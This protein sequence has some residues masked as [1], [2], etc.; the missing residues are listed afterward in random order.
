[1][2]SSNIFPATLVFDAQRHVV[3]VNDQPIVLS[4]TEFRILE[5]LA[6]SPGRAFSREQILDGLYGDKY[7]ITPRAVD[8][9]MVG[10]R[11]KLG[12]AAA[13]I[14]TVRGLGYRLQDGR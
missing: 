6:A 7:A 5:F 2:N 1:M 11:R 13:A 14:E 8:V 3:R 12:P 9:Q 10:I 4:A